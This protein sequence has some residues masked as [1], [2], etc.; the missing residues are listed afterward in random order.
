MGH[1]TYSAGVFLLCA[2]HVPF[3]AVAS[4]CMPITTLWY[5]STVIYARLFCLILPSSL[6]LYNGLTD[7]ANRC[8][9]LFLLL[10]HG[11]A[12]GF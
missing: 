10:S 8:M 5:Y 2:I 12:V 4:F 9:C 11:Q 6:M 7:G 1:D 3:C